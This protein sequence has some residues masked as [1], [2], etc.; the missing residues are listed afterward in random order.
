MFIFKALCFET[1][2]SF[3]SRKGMES[4]KCLSQKNRGG[5]WVQVSDCVSCSRWWLSSH[6]H[7]KA[8]ALTQLGQVGQSMFMPDADINHEHCFEICPYQ[9][10]PGCS[11]AIIGQPGVSLRQRV[12]LLFVAEITD[13][14][15]PSTHFGWVVG[16]KRAGR[17]AWDHG[18]AAVSP[19]PLCSPHQ[20][21]RSTK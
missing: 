18:V 21:H 4:H 15:K 1:T 13:P 5:V 16:N 8:P 17:W 7:F 3:S 2:S 20:K 6:L 11:V 9:M 14:S 19:S 10:A 12:G